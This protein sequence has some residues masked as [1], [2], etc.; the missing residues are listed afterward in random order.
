MNRRRWLIIIALILLGAIVDNS[1]PYPANKIPNI[2][3]SGPVT[4][5]G[6]HPCQTDCSVTVDAAGVMHTRWES[7]FA[8][9]ADAVCR[10]I[11]PTPPPICR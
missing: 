2:P 8:Y 7:A 4:H 3:G 6:R 10:R 1:P 9:S 11:L 5:I